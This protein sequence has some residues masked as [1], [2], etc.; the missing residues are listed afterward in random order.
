MEM[1]IWKNFITMPT[2]A[3]GICAYCACENTAS[4]APY[5]R[6][7]LLIAAIAATRLICDRKLVPPSVRIRPQ[8]A[9]RSAQSPRRGRM[10]RICSRYHTESAAVAT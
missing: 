6:S 4:S 3:I 1:T 10:M 5:L 8:T 7:I 9:P 2:T